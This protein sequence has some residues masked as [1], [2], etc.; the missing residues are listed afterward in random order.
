MIYAAGDIEPMVRVLSLSSFLPFILTTAYMSNPCGGIG[1]GMLRAI[2]RQQP[3]CHV[4][5]KAIW[6]GSIPCAYKCSFEKTA[7]SRVRE[8]L[9]LSSRDL[10]RHSLIAGGFECVGRSSSA[11]RSHCGC[12]CPNLAVFCSSHPGI[13]P[14]TLVG[15]LWPLLNLRH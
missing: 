13:L 12:P 6:S 10:N 11:E 15:C 4:K 2:E 8:S 5:N 9:M 1:G 7:Y 14:L 3:P